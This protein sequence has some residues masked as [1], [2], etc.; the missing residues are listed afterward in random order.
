MVDEVYG[1]DSFYRFVEEEIVIL[2]SKIC[3]EH[4]QMI[5]TINGSKITG[6]KN[7]GSAQFKSFLDAIVNGNKKL[8]KL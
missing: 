7:S 2:L 8:N 6:Q 3:G 5:A 1:D 4:E